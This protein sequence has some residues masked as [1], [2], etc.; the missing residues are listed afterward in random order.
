MKIKQLHENV[1]DELAAIKAIEDYL[2]QHEIYGQRIGRVLT[3]RPLY[4]VIR[5]SVLGTE[6]KIRLQRRFH[7]YGTYRVN[8][9]DP[10]S[11]PKILNAVKSLMRGHE[12]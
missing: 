8:L 4:A 6:A 12:A 2:K 1:G 7:D 11:F 3:V 5:I 10:K 9:Y